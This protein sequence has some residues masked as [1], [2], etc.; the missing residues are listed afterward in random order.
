MT[1]SRRYDDIA[2]AE[3]K[4]TLLSAYSLWKIRARKGEKCSLMLNI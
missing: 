2:F 3:L 4:K 1:L